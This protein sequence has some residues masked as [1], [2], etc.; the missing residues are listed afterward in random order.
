MSQNFKDA[1]A[2]RGRSTAGPFHYRTYRLK[3]QEPLKA[4]TL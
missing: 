1:I 2:W 4:A 3:S